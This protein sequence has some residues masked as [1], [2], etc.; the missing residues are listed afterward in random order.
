[1]LKTQSLQEE[2][3]VP[4]FNPNVLASLWVDIYRFHLYINIK[5]WVKKSLTA[6]F[7]VVVRCESSK[8][9]DQFLYGWD[10]FFW[11]AL[12]IW[13]KKKNFWFYNKTKAIFQP[14][15]SS[16]VWI[17]NEIIRC[18]IGHTTNKIFPLFKEAYVPTTHNYQHIHSQVLTCR[19]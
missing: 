2:K 19:L 15:L 8:S 11:L 10:L 12:K 18:K 5:Q 13:V 7:V 4:D 14:Y 6:K 3:D 1:M 9:R 17:N 16:N